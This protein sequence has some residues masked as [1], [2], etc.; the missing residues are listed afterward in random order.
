MKELSIDEIN[1]LNN[2]IIIDD[3]LIHK[4]TKSEILSQAMTGVLVGRKF[5]GRRPSDEGIASIREFQLGR[6]KSNKTR[7]KLSV[8]GKNAGRVQTIEEKLNRSLKMIGKNTGKRSDED[9]YKMAEGKSKYIYETP[10][11]K[12]KS[13]LQVIESFPEYTANQLD[14]MIENNKNG[15]SREKII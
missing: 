7:E 6:P 12:M 2:N 1:S 14:R 5:P 4:E 10:S 3:I 13:R 8:K 15:F 9:R 11:G